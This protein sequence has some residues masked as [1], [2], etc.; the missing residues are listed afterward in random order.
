MVEDSD[1]QLRCVGDI[2]RI[3]RAA[4]LDQA[5]IAEG[6][7]QHAGIAVAGDYGDRMSLDRR[8]ANDKTFGAEIGERQVQAFDDVGILRRAQNNIAVAEGHRHGD[9]GAKQS[10]ETALQ[11]VFGGLQGRAVTPDNACGM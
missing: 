3:D 4:R 10:F 7:I 2:E 8:R 5:E 9:V 6:T 11:F 1:F